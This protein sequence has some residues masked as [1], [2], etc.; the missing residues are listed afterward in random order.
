MSEELD[1]SEKVKGK[2][3]LQLEK[4]DEM[5]KNGELDPSNVKFTTWQDK[6]NDE[7]EVIGTAR[8]V[9]EEDEELAKVE[10][11]CPRCQH[12]GFKETEYKRPF[13]VECEGCEKSFSV[14]RLK[15]KVDRENKEDPDV[16]V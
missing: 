15:D 12:R 6:R 1:D 10:Y 13:W 2:E 11:I 8:V 14:P 5:V 9:Q 3:N 16:D 7:G 4:I